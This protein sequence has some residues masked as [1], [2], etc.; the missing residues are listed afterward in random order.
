MNDVSQEMASLLQEVALRAQVLDLAVQ[1]LVRSLDASSSAS[2]AAGLRADAV[3][4]LNSH[5]GRADA[6]ADQ[7]LTLA[8][9]ALLEAA[10]HPPKT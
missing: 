5:A 1:N 6:H 2:F 4:L 9:A 7:V 8:I 3:G 10:G